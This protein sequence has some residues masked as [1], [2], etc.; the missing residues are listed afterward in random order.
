VTVANTGLI[1][2][3]PEPLRAFAPRARTFSKDLMRTYVHTGYHVHVLAHREVFVRIGNAR[4][5]GGYLRDQRRQAGLSQTELCER[6]LVSRRWLSNLEAGKPT[7]EVGLVLRVVAAL[8][9]TVELRPAPAP[10]I[11]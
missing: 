10:E 8:D 11:A 7:A 2:P 9:L 6:A 1:G 5:L 4:D 3:S